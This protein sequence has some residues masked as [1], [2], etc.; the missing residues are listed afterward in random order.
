MI[1]YIVR[2]KV[3]IKN[4]NVNFPQ[5]VDR[6]S[7]VQ[8][9]CSPSQEFLNVRKSQKGFHDKDDNWAAQRWFT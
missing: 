2:P 9:L 6:R 5:A 8:M 3:I 7:N 4:L 1:I